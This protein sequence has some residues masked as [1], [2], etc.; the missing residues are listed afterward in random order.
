GL[1]E[2]GGEDVAHADR[3][4]RVVTDEARARA[5]GFAVGDRGR[6]ALEALDGQNAVEDV[7][8][9]QV[10][11]GGCLGGVTGRRDRLL[12]VE[13]VDLDHRGAGDLVLQVGQERVDVV[14][15]RV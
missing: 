8:V 2:G 4:D 9:G 12:R 7:E 5:T 1:V 6:A 3:D 13:Q 10:H 15:E 14:L 11:G